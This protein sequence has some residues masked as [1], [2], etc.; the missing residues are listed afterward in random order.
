M[1]DE[2]AL[3][4]ME[5]SIRSGPLSLPTV[6]LALIAEVRRLRDKIDCICDDWG[7]NDGW[8]EWQDD[9]HRE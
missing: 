1:I 3:D 5:A 6:A 7:I 9:I 4:E 8:E 2:K